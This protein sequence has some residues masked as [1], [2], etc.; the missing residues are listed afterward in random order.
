[1]KKDKN[2][3][4]L[5]IFVLCILIAWIVGAVIGF[6]QEKMDAENKTYNKIDEDKDGIIYLNV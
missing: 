5:V 2:K 3:L 4:I 6:N 1:M